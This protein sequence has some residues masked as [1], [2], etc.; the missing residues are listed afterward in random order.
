MERESISGV[1]A[2]WWHLLD[3]GRIQCDLC[4]RDCKLHEGQRG[5]CFV[6][7]RQGDAMLLTTYGR[8]SGFC[9]DPVEK[10]PLNH[11][12]PGSSILSF[13]TAGC[14]LACKFCQNWDI[15]KSREMD[16]LMDDA[17]PEAIAL[18]AQR[19]GAKSVAFTYND[20]VIFAEYAMDTADACHAHGINA[21]AVTAGYMHAAPA[22]EFYAKMDA[23]NV[24]LKAFS[25][26]FYVKLCGAHLT[27]VLDT[28]AYIAHDT[29]CWLE[30]T[31]LLI[32]G[33][34][35]ADAELKALAAWVMQELGPDVPLH[36]SAFHP[37]YKLDDVPATSAATLSRARRI[38]LDAGLHYVYTGNV[39]D[40][41]GDITLCPGCGAAVI[42]R[43]WYEI[44]NYS[45][46]D[47]GKCQH[48]GTAIA[49]RFGSF[50]TPFGARRIPVRLHAAA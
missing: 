48:C 41:E 14:N 15:S 11:F 31:T 44:L 10:K 8:S 46:T 47:D 13:G 5:A 9:I 23:A 34:N 24:D 50:E 12:H 2:L 21:V 7:G 16:T 40:R 33:R 6:R 26:D 17:T 49:G 27:P 1:P 20:P 19:Y 28:L 30:I 37:D 42:E 43:D 45:L 22:R 25:D 39:H 4:P 29:Q 3:D 32:P 38:A 36:F 18:A 35:D